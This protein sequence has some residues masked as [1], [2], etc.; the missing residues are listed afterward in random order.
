MLNTNPPGTFDNQQWV[1]LIPGIWKVE[2]LDWQSPGNT[3]TK[4]N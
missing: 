3:Y 2:W 4:K 1:E